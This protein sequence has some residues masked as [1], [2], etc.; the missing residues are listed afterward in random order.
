MRGFLY[1]SFVIPGGPQAIPGARNHWETIP[2]STLRRSL[3]LGLPE[4][5]S[6]GPGMALSLTRSPHPARDRGSARNG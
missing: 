6:E 2:G 5:R 1:Q 3:P 4:A